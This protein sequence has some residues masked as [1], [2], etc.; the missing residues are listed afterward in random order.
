MGLWPLAEGHLAVRCR[1]CIGGG[2]G[3]SKQQRWFR[4]LKVFSAK[5]TCIFMDLTYQLP[6]NSA[7]SKK[8][9]LPTPSINSSLV[10]KW[11]SRPF[12][13]PG[14]GFRV[15]WETEKP[16]VL[17]WF[18]KR[19]L[20]RVDFPVPEGPQITSGCCKHQVSARRGLEALYA[21]AVDDVWVD[22]P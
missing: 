11:Y 14:L 20:R 5:L 13:S 4:S 9:P 12:S 22:G 18:S 8:S 6:P 1:E 2:E 10:T 17:G 19:V 15:V 21:Y 16:K 7:H 3:R